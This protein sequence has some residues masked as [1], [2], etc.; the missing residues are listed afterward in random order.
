[1]FECIKRLFRKKEVTPPPAPIEPEPDTKPAAIGLLGIDLELFRQNLTQNLAIYKPSQWDG[2][3]RIT[4]EFYK[5]NLKDLRQ[6]AYI[7]AT[8]MWETASTM[9]PIT[10]YG[11]DAYLRAKKYW[12]FVGRG[13]VQLTW[14]F[15]YAKYGIKDNPERALEPEFAA[16]VIVDGMK[17]GTF[18][19]KYLELY[20]NDKVDSPYEA[21][22]IVNGLD[23][24]I[25]IAEYHKRILWA[26][27]ES[28]IT[29]QIEREMLL[30]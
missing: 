27:N 17:N 11:G 23:K 14:D 12:P 15:N 22:R 21:R 28:R 16:F 3:E 8:A 19:G 29:G 4:R 25:E 18:T 5:Q 2:F 10:E 30:S 6:L 13:Y 20:F 26:L 7:L 1:M 9:R 24:A